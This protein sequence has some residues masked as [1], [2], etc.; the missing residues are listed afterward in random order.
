MVVLT[1]VVDDVASRPLRAEHGYAMWISAPGG[2]VL[3]DTGG[4]GDVL[5]GIISSLLA[6]GLTSMDAA[7]LGAYVHGLSADMLLGRMSGRSMLPTDVA[8]DWVRE[9]VI[10]L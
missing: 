10:Q 9:V 3:L 1:W 8:A 5:T 2:Q 7:I 6:Q 4:S